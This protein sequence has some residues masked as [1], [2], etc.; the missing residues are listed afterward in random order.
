MIN[1][2]ESYFYMPVLNHCEDEDLSEGAMN[3]GI[4]S[5]TI[6]IRGI[7]TAAED[8]MISRDIIMSEYLNIPIH[9]STTNSNISS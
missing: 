8:I 7:P 5:T 6:G 4:T 3:E 2:F 9:L 1:M